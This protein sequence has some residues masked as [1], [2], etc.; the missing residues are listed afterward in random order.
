MAVHLVP[1]CRLKEH[2]V[3]DNGRVLFLDQLPLVGPVW[4]QLMVSIS[5]VLKQGSGL[6]VAIKF[7]Q[8]IAPGYQC[9]A[10]LENASCFAKEPGKVKPA[11]Y[12]SNLKLPQFTVVVIYTA[13]SKTNQ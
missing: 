3:W 13:I 8:P 2:G 4:P 1:N 5:K 7:W 10:R 6:L 11:E 12:C 9:A